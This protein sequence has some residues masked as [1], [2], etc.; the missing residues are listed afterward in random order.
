MF[1]TVFEISPRMTHFGQLMDYGGAIAPAKNLAEENAKTAAK[2][3]QSIVYQQKETVIKEIIREKEVEKTVTIGSGYA[4][5]SQSF[6][7]TPGDL[8][9][10]ESKLLTLINNGEK[11]AV[12]QSAN[13]VTQNI[14]NWAPTQKIDNLSNITVN[15]SFTVSGMLWPS[16][17]GTSG[18]VLATNG[19]GN[20]YWATISSGRGHR[21]GSAFFFI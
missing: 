10:L 17:R 18:Q 7:A 19:S 8:S 1:K 3:S 9:A 4:P 5:D 20:Y 16:D 13:Y 14:Y 21:D 15:G 6:Y 11:Q 12:Q 2:S